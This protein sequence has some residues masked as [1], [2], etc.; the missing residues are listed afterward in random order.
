METLKSI[1]FYLI[2]A[3]A[4]LALGFGAGKATTKP[5]II[6]QTKV[7]TIIKEVEVKKD[8]IVT[9]QHEVIKP[10][11][12]KVIDTSTVD[13][14]ID[15]TS[16]DTS[17]VSS[18][19]TKVGTTP[20]KWHVSLAANRANP[21]LSETYYNLNVEKRLLGP[22]FIGVTASTHKEAGLMIGFEF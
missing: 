18:S 2:G 19:T 21:L 10:D 1:K 15:S 14:S 12:T 4:L 16:T 7:E 6:T 3:L 13:K 11:G 5:Q 20:P 8:N 17:T 9:Q 22:F